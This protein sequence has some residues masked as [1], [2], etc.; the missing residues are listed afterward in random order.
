M[1]QF[2]LHIENNEKI[3]DGLNKKNDLL[4]VSGEKMVIVLR[5]SK[6][7]LRIKEYE[8]SPAGVAR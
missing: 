6:T 2:A 1:R 8:N 3:I 7:R 4:S 5:F